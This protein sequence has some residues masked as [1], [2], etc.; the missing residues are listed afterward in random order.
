MGCPM[1]EKKVQIQRPTEYPFEELYRPWS[2]ILSSFTNIIIFACLVLLC[3]ALYR[4]SRS[5]RKTLGKTF[6]RQVKA[7]AAIE[8]GSRVKVLVTGGCGNFGQCLIENL[9]KDGGYEIHSLDLYIPDEDS[10]L[11]GVSS[12]ISADVTDPEAIRLALKE[13]GAEAV[14]HVAGLI[15][16]VGI[17]DSTFYHV[18]KTGTQNLIDACKKLGVARF[19][20]TSTCDVLMSKEK[21]E[22][23]NNVDETWPIPKHSLNAYCGSKKE[24]EEIVIRA[25]GYEGLVTCSLRCAVVAH[26][27]S[28][29]FHAML[30]SRGAYINN[31]TNK[32]SLV[33]ADLC[34][35]A[36]ILAEKKLREG[37]SSVAAGQAYNLAGDSY[38]TK[39]IMEYSPDGSDITIW[40]HPQ[41]IS[42][43]KWLISI[44]A[45]INMFVYFVSGYAPFNA[46]LDLN[47]V[48]FLSHSYTFNSSKAKRELG[49]GQHP[50]WQEVVEKIVEEFEEEQET[51]KKK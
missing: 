21:N 14:F 36:H 38:T 32:L 12:F 43:P 19:V 27:N 25:N 50:S 33:D 5:E 46:G 30:Q 22:I 42:I 11:P 24:A 48:E 41:P 13:T 8:G 49:W 6:F 39:E 16:R 51:K 44:L 26:Y 28:L 2:W 35:Q 10:R 40:G 7:E 9:V 4:R 17:K 3:Y 23:L 31:G 29:M 45:I 15:P 34:S 47:A 18:N 20:F 37:K 1:F